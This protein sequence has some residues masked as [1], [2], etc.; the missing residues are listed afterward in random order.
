MAPALSRTLRRNT[1]WLSGD[2]SEAKRRF[3]SRK[4]QAKAS[5]RSNPPRGI[6]FGRLERSPPRARMESGLTTA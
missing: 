4:R 6:P 2:T 5:F 1:S 3:A